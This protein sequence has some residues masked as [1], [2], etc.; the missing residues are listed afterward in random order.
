MS[1]RVVIAGTVALAS[2]AGAAVAFLWQGIVFLQSSSWP[3]LSVAAVLRWADATLWARL[4]RG[5]PEGHALLDKA[6]LS[7]ALVGL[8][9]LGYVVAKWGSS[10]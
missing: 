6:P 8:A 4:A 10:R 2:L 3:K 1:L 9:V 5:W 7:L